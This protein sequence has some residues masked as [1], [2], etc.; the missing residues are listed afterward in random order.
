MKKLHEMAVP[1]GY[2]LIYADPPWQYRD[3]ASAGKR[4]ACHKY[5]VMALDEICALPVADIGWGTGRE[6]TPKIVCWLPAA[7]R[8]E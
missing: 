6:E 3:K 8:Q 1:G 4:G 2:R 5:Q 7:G